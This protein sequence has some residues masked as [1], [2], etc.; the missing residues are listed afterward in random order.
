MDL[1]Y[2]LK[3]WR[4]IIKQRKE[5]EKRIDPAKLQNLNNSIEKEINK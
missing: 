4:K 1:N 3:K 5:A 2:H